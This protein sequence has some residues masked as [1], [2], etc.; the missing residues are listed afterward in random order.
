MTNPGRVLHTDN[1]NSLNAMIAQGQKAIDIVRTKGASSPPTK[2]FVTKHAELTKKKAALEK[3][4][5][6]IKAGVGRTS[7]DDP[8]VKNLLKDVTLFVKEAVAE[9]KKKKFTTYYFGTTKVKDLAALATKAKASLPALAQ[10]AVL[11][12]LNDADSGDAK[13]ASRAGTGVR[14]ASA[15]KMGTA[16]TATV[17]FTRT[18]ADGS[19]ETIL[20]V[21]GV[22]C[23]ET[24]SG[25]RIHASSISTL[26][27]GE[28]FTL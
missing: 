7:R 2:Y 1:I 13:E 27:T 5:E 21:V 4:I 8:S 26:R 23:H 14:H 18:T 24:S 3:R 19:L 11:G 16:K 12:A 17:F 9:S 15:G 6:G 28:V 25:Y 22:G 10:T 20:K